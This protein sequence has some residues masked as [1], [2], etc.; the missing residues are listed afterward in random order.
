[1]SDDFKGMSYSDLVDAATRAAHDGLLREGASGLR[2]AL[3][4]W[5]QAYPQWKTANEEPV[6]KKKAKAS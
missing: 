2:T 4:N 1:M 5:L 3:F 6:K